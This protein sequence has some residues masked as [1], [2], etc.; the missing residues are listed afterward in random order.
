M[1]KPASLFYPILVF[2]IAQLVWICLLGLWIYWYVTNYVLLS[3]VEDQVSS[4]LTGDSTNIFALVGGIV[5]LVLLSVGMSLI[6]VYSTRQLNIR[7][8]YDSFIA[9]VTHELKSPLSSIQLYLETMNKRNVSQE[10]Q[11][12]FFFTMLS[13]V[14][15]L[16]RLINSILYLS[17][18]E[19]SKLKRKV[20]HDYHIYD[21]DSVIQKIVGE[22]CKHFKLS[23]ESL[24][25]EGN[26]DCRCVIDQNWLM[27]VFNNLIDNAMKYSINPPEIKIILGRGK[28]YFYIHFIDKGIGIIPRDQKRIFHKFQRIYNPESPN[29]KGTGLGLYWVKEIVGYHGGKITVRSAGKNQGTTF[30]I[31]LPVYKASK[32][33]YINRLLKLSIKEKPNRDEKNEQQE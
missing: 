9:N 3:Q 25:I 23:P 11:R 13:D 14:E 28:K 31:S 22:A 20:V 30:T 4:R 29:V 18:L 19:K 33:R 26:A 17:S 32:K 27:I 6:F 21:T 16:N 15:R 10:K 8:H 7:R 12:D 1:K 5:L 24:R 2:L